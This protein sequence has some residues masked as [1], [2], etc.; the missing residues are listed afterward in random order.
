MIA[1]LKIDKINKAL[2]DLEGSGEADLQSV[3]ASANDKFGC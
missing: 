1:V 2:S 3:L